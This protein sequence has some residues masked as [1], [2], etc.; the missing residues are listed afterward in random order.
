MLGGAIVIAVAAF[1]PWLTGGGESANAFDLTNVGDLDDESSRGAGMMFFAVVI[2]GLGAA[3]LAFRR[4]LAV[5]I[6]AL[7]FAAIALLRSLADIG[8]LNELADVVGEAVTVGPGV[9]VF[10]LGS[11][12]ALAG[13]IWGLTVRRQ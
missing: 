6:I 2:G 12:V 13:T 9:Y 11:A 7:V 1:L 3:T 10:A 4:N 8:D 5:V